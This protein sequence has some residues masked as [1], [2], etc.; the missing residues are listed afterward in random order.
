[1]SSLYSIAHLHFYFNLTCSANFHGW[2]FSGHLHEFRFLCVCVSLAN[3]KFLLHRKAQHTS[4]HASSAFFFNAL[5]SKA[6]KCVFTYINWWIFPSR[7]GFETLSLS[8][9]LLL[10]LLLF[11]L[12]ILSSFFF[13]FH[14]VNC[15]KSAP[16]AEQY[17][18]SLAF[19]AELT[20]KKLRN[21]KGKHWLYFFSAA[22]FVW[23]N[24]FFRSCSLFWFVFCF[25]RF[26]YDFFSF[27][28]FLSIWYRIYCTYVM[29]Y[30]TCVLSHTT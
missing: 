4:S 19:N 18:I 25:S 24:V 13:C 3:T 12:I 15:Q 23:C 9:S 11:L 1:M 2:L 28:F 20:K 29:C 7:V 14:L 17:R 6:F 27:L 16:S 10:L 5:M 21:G 8:C 30:T 26:L 22:G